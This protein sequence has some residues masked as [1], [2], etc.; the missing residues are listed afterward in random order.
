MG[1]MADEW[2]WKWI[3]DF[4]SIS[5]SYVTHGP[6]GNR[7]TW[8]GRKWLST[9][10]NV[11]QSG[12]RRWE[13]LV[14]EALIKIEPFCVDTPITSSLFR[15]N[16]A[17]VEPDT[18]ESLSNCWTDRFFTLP[19]HFVPVVSP[20]EEFQRGST[21]SYGCVKLSQ[22]VCTVA[23]RSACRLF[24]EDRWSNVG[25]DCCRLPT[26]GSWNNLSGSKTD[27]LH[28]RL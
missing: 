9:S 4:C 13:R 16:D 26:T 15:D 7:F 2:K 6:V 12:R 14:K 23:T 28:G 20:I 5:Q 10:W 1:A 27:A 25:G 3:G 19:W 11:R 21:R 22:P 24:A 17:C 8:W 18:G